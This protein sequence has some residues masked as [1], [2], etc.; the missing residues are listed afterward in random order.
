MPI[1]FTYNRYSQTL[2]MKHAMLIYI[3]EWMK[4]KCMC[5]NDA[6]S[7]DEVGLE[8]QNAGAG[9]NINFIISAY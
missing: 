4:N 1:K 7:K 5:K 2:F 9:N 8:M 3:L 6:G